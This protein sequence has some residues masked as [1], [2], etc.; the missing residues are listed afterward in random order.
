MLAHALRI[1][2]AMSA[3]SVT[4]ARG[5]SPPIYHMTVLLSA[6]N[7][8]SADVTSFPDAVAVPLAP[9]SMPLSVDQGRPTQFAETAL[10][11]GQQ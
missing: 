11:R 4:S 2:R 8:A 7:S 1:I 10:V 3:I 9:T 6:Q 5:S